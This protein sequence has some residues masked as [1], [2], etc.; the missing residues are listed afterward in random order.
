MDL[1]GWVGGFGVYGP[2]LKLKLAQPNPPTERQAN[3]ATELFV[4]LWVL[5]FYTE[6]TIV[7]AIDSKLVHDAMCGHARKWKDRGWRCSSGPVGNVSCW[8]A[9]VHHM[10]SSG[11]EVKAILSPSHCGI[12]GNEVAN[13]LAELRRSRNSFNVVQVDRA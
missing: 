13:D 1:V 7:I 9:L 8:G 5:D 6:G 2:Q 12:L 4:V 10:E 3:N 11:H